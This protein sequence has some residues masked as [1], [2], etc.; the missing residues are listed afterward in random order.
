MFY[1]FLFALQLMFEL[2]VDVLHRILLLPQL[3]DP[4]TQL[5]V[6]GRQLI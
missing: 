3:V 4:L 5:V 2:A 1:V 6:L